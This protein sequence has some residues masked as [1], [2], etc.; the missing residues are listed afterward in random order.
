[1]FQEKFHWQVKRAALLDSFQECS[2]GLV[3]LVL[4]LNG[5]D[6]FHV[7]NECVEGLPFYIDRTKQANQNWTTIR[8][9]E[10]STKITLE[11]KKMRWMFK[12]KFHWQEKRAT[13][14]GSFQECSSSRL[15]K[16]KCLP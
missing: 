15:V 1:M 11:K 10:N 3:L 9:P 8:T 13:L 16:C 6:F 4:A 5:E 14:L 2:S 12:E 7:S